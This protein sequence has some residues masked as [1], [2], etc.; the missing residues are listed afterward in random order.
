[1]NYRGIERTGKLAF[2]LK[3]SVLS[4]VLLLVV[5]V[6]KSLLAG[7]YPLDKLG[8]STVL[9]INILLSLSLVSLIFSCAV[10]GVLLFGRIFVLATPRFGTN[11]V[12]SIG[13]LMFASSGVFVAVL[14]FRL[15]LVY[16]FAVNV[17]FWDEWGTE[18]NTIKAYCSNGLTLREL[19]VPH[20]EHYV[21][22]SKL[23]WIFSYRMFG[24]MNLIRVMQLQSVIPAITASLA[25]LVVDKGDSRI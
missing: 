20:G 12:Q 9:F 3:W 25:V 19:F 22:F 6:F 8:N 21:V 13:V 17:P 14:L 24:S 10:V 5:L 2:W 4:A 7:F 23:L 16:C 11:Q 15:I 18:L 1:M